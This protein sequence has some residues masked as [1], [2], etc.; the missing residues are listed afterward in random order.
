VDQ[1]GQFFGLTFSALLPLV[2]PLGCAL[3]ML[4]LVGN[5][6]ADVYREL[7]K[8]IAINTTLFLLAIQ[9]IGTALLKFFGISLPVMQVAGGLCLAVMGWNLLNG[10]EPQEP[11]P[12]DQPALAQRP[13]REVLR[14]KVFYPFTFPITAGPGC[15]VVVI[16]LSAHASAH[17]I[18]PDLA[19]HAG[20]VLAV[21]VLSVLVYVCYAYAPVIAARVPADTAQGILR[22]IAFFLLCIGVQ[23]V[24]NGAEAMLKT[25]FKV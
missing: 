25:V 5:A 19:A 13:P 11:N 3:V 8:N 12:Q 17:T 6:P 4:A 24:W 20:I 18:L 21:V 7:A 1:L 16:T 15:I 22:V 9:L 10:A 14:R 2:N 23:I